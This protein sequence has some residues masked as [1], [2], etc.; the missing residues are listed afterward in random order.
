VLN[1][2]TEFGWTA[3]H[4]CCLYGTDDPDERFA[5]VARKLIVSGADTTIVNSRGKTAWEVA[6]QAKATTVLAVFTELAGAHTQLG[7]ELA[8]YENRPDVEGEK[9]RDD[10]ELDHRRFTL[11][12]IVEGSCEDYTR[13]TGGEP[14]AEGGFGKVF[15]HSDVSPSIEANGKLFREVVLKV[16]KPDGVAEL[17]G[18]VKSLHSLSHENVVQI[19]GMTEGP[20]PGTAMAWQMILECVHCKRLPFLVSID[21]LRY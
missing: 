20:A 7:T 13:S 11:W 3:L 17:K 4:W 14:L 18:E 5:A 2:Q 12:D 16:P 21:V 15:R 1:T 9:F 6:R 19:L 10:L 8:R